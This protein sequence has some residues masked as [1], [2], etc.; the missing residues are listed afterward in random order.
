M[1]GAID[2]F[3]GSAHRTPSYIALMHGAQ[4]THF[5][6]QFGV[7]K[8][9]WFYVINHI[10]NMTGTIPGASDVRNYIKCPRI[11]MKMRK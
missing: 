1:L 2:F 10:V 8:T 9:L 6:P 7:G 3:V 11:G 5:R 4:T